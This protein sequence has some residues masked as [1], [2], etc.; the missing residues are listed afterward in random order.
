[1]RNSTDSADPPDLPY[2][3]RAKIGLVIPSNNTVIEPELWSMRPAG[4]TVHGHRIQARGNTP[5]GIVEME[6][7]ADRAVG[8]L[9]H[10]RMTAIMYSCLATSLVKGL[11][12]TRSVAARIQ[13]STSIPAGTAAGATFDAVRSTGAH[14]VAIAS[15]YPDRIQS[16]LPPF[17][18]EYGLELVSARNMGIQNSLE[19]WKIS[20][21]TLREFVRAADHPKAEVMCI[22]ATDL[23]TVVEI[24]T[25][26][27]ELGKPVITTNQAILWKALALCGIDQPIQGFGQLLE[28]ARA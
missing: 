15:P 17:V 5:E 18:A 22:V 16:L 7:S 23:P 19:L 25:L 3:H 2:G 14:R 20:G 26:E 11:D 10:G 9:A 13:T 8:E 21:D 6:K 1:M 24:A 12:W 4:V 28:K 27:Q